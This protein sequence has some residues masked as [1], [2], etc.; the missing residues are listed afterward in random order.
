MLVP[1]RYLECS[2]LA[3]VVL[4]ADTQN[5]FIETNVQQAAFGPNPVPGGS[6]ARNPRPLSESVP[7][8]LNVD[9][10]TGM[11]L[12]IEELTKAVE[13]TDIS[14]AGWG[15]FTMTVFSSTDITI[16]LNGPKDTQA[17]F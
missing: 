2:S 4:V 5:K 7:G 11:C 16:T 1:V 9:A 17:D 10:R 12:D 3:Y 6:A 15:C 14:D 8:S 13:L